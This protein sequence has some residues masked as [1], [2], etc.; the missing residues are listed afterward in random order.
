[1][2]E[3]NGLSFGIGLGLG[4]LIGGLFVYTILKAPVQQQTSQLSQSTQPTL[5]ERLYTQK[6]EKRLTDEIDKT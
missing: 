1:M 3:N 2:S 5:L 4:I 6:L